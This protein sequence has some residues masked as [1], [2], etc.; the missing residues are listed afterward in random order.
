M[1]QQKHTDVFGVGNALVDILAFVEDDFVAQLGFPKGSMNLVDTAKR[2][3]IL[4]GLADTDLR[5][6]GG[7][8]AA[9]SLFAIAQCGGSAIFA[10]KV[11]DDPDGRFFIDDLK[12]NGMRYGVEGFYPGDAP[13]GTS[14]ILTTPDAERTM[15]THLGV[16]IEL[17]AD[18]IL[19]SQITDCKM[20]YVEG[21]LWSGPGTRAAALKALRIASESGATRCFTFSDAFLVDGFAEDFRTLLKEDCDLVFCNADEARRF[22]GQ[23]DLQQAAADMA[24]L[25]EHA[26][27]TDGA[28]GCLV[29]EK[30]SIQRVEGFK[31]AAI[32]TVGA[33][34]AFAGGVMYGLCHGFTAIQSARLG[35]YLA[36][37]VV[38][39]Q[40]PRLDN[41][42]KSEIAAIVG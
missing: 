39:V 4:N 16:S 8:S 2:T 21:Y 10:G 20:C 23:A 12:A 27:I 14:I 7:G 36:S 35:N 3:E 34:D 18:D 13:S 38:T 24:K 31:V 9:N 37:K 42:D 33:G 30:G 25:V 41:F 40:G 17:Q 1:A 26:F 15:C 28:S 22:S 32:D 6:R 11:S 5:K 29:I 19:E